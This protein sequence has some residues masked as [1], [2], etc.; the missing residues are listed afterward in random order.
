[1]TLK[2]FIKHVYYTEH[3]II[4]PSMGGFRIIKSQFMKKGV[5]NSKKIKTYLTELYNNNY[6]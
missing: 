4:V 1:M 6:K 3:N 5:I 2:E